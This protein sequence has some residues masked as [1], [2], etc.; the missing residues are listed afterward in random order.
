MLNGLNALLKFEKMDKK[1]NIK[2]YIKFLFGGSQLN[3]E[4]N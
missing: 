1:K 4:K 2:R 3:E